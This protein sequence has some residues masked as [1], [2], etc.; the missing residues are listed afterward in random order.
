M[1]A[2]PLVAVAAWAAFGPWRI[3]LQPLGA[4]ERLLL[5]RDGEAASLAVI[6][7]E[8]GHRSI[9]LNHAYLLGSS[10]AAA[11]ELRQGRL[12][13]LLHPEPKRVAFIGVAT[14]ITASAVLDFPVERAVAV[15]LVPGVVAALPYFAPLE[16][17]L[18]RGSARA[19]LVVDDGRNF[20][21]GTS[22]RFDVIVSDL[23]V[24]WHAGTGDLY[25]LEHFRTAAERLAPGGHLRAMAARLSARRPRAARGDRDLPARVPARAAL[26]RGLRCRSAACWRWSVRRSALTSSTPSAR[27]PPA[28]GSPRRVGPSP[29]LA[30]PSG[31]LL[32][33][34]ADA[35][36]LR[37]WAHGAP[38]NTDDRPFIEYA[39]PG[40]LLRHRQREVDAVQQELVRFRPRVLREPSSS[41]WRG[42]PSELF[43]LADRLHDATLA[44][45]SLRFEREFRILEE[46]ARTRRRSRAGSLRGVAGGG[47]AAPA[48]P[49]RA[50]RGAARIARGSRMRWRVWLCA[51]ALAHCASGDPSLVWLAK[52]DG[53]VQCERCRAPG[54]AEVVARI[55]AGGVRVHDSTEHFVPVCMACGVCASGRSY[56]VQIERGHTD[57]LVREGWSAMR[58]PPAGAQGRK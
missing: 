31:L 39:T 24:P 9:K 4:G 17:R 8:N 43:A 55:E 34:L 12:P 5:Y 45:V 28:R 26:A 20:L 52:P 29:F 25:A 49:R 13:L 14:G 57:R 30:S 36:A 6:G 53:C 3:H 41:R 15:E 27:A 56:A 33:Y 22:E 54:L 19:G 46:L 35:D 47:G 23:F 1:A 21:L 37:D 7:E 48:R 50:Q 51:L 58:E 2:L 10:G 32:L 16:R 18:L 38:L 44:H 42:P 40:S 11:L